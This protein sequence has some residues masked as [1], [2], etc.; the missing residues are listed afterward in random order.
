MGLS[1]LESFRKLIR[2][3]TVRVGEP[4][5]NIHGAV[6]V[7]LADV[8]EV[9]TQTWLVLRIN[10]SQLPSLIDY[11][12]AFAEQSSTLTLETAVEG[13][14]SVTSRPN[15]VL[16]LRSVVAVE[17]SSSFNLD[18]TVPGTGA[19]AAVYLD[20]T[21]LRTVSGTV[22]V[23]VTVT[24]GRHTLYVLVAAPSVAVTVPTRVSLIG[25]TDIP[26]APQWVSTETGYLDEGAGTARNI[27]RWLSDPEVGSYRVYRREPVLLAN[28]LKAGDGVVTESTALGADNTYAVVIAGDHGQA[29][30]TGSVLLVNGEAVGIVTSVVV[31]QLTA[32]NPATTEVDESTYSTAVT[33]RLPVELETLPNLVG[34]L[35]Y[36][37]SFNEIARVSRVVNTSIV[38]YVDSA[39]NKDRAY[40]YV[41]RATGLVDET[42]LSPMSTVRYMV[43][44][45][46]TPP[47]PIDFLDDYP[48]ILNRQVTVKFQTPTDLDYAGVNVY[49]RTEIQNSTPTG[50]EPYGVSSISG[51]RL[52][53]T[54]DN[55]EFPVEVDN[56][57]T[58]YLLQFDI[59]EY[60]TYVFTI[61]SNTASAVTLTEAIPQ[62]I[63]TA[64]S[65][66]PTT[67]GMLIFK[68]TQIRT[69]AGLPNR[70]DELQ[71][72]ADNYG[73][74]FFCSFD[75]AGN[76]QRLADAVT[77]EYTP[78]NDVFSQ[79]PV[80]GIRQLVESEQNVFVET[81][82]ATTTLNSTT[83]TVSSTSALVAGMAVRGNANIP[84]GTTVISVL[85]GTTVQL[86]NPATAAGT[87][88]TTFALDN[89]VQYALLELWAYNPGVADAAKFDGVTLYYQREVQDAQ[90]IALNPIPNSDRPFPDLIQLE[91]VTASVTTTAGSVTATMTDTSGLRLGM[92]I[93][94]N[95]RIPANTT[96]ATVVNATTFTLS[97]NATSTG[98]GST[99]FTLTA[100]AK[101]VVDN[102]TATRSRFV[103]LNREY[104]IIRVWAETGSGLSSDITT[105]IADLDTTPEVQVESYIN[106]LNNT[107]RFSVVADDDTNGFSWQ[108]DTG[109]V[110][111]V[112]TRTIKRV[113]VDGIP[114]AL[115]ERK[116][117]RVVPY[118]RYV[119]GPPVQLLDPGSEVVL[120]LVRTPRSSVVFDSKDSAGNRSSIAVTATFSM[121]PAP[122]KL[123]SNRAGTITASGGQYVL[124]DSQTPGWTT[125]AFRTTATGFFYL[126][127][128]P[129][130]GQ[131]RPTIVR[132]IT[133][134]TSNTLTIANNLQDYVGIGA[135]AYDILDGAVLVRRVP[136]TGGPGAFLPTAGKEYYSRSDEAFEIE[137]YA[138]KNG[139]YPENVRRAFIDDDTLPRLRDFAYSQTTIGGETFTDLGFGSADDDA[140]FW[141]VYEKKGG[142]PTTDGQA[143]TTT[144]PASMSKI[145][146]A[147][148]RF[149]GSI[150]QTSYR[151]SAASMTANDLW[152]A[153]AV[154]KNSFGEVGY[155]ATAQLTVGATELPRIGEVTLVPNVGTNTVTVTWTVSSTTNPATGVIVEAYRSD[156]Q[157]APVQGN[158][159]AGGSFTLNVGETIVAT[160][161]VSRNWV[162]SATLSGYNTITR[163]TTFQVQSG[164]GG[165]GGGL[166]FTG[167][168][169]IYDLGS[170]D[171]QSCVSP[172]SR[173]HQRRIIWDLTIPGS[174]LTYTSPYLVNIEYA[175][176]TATTANPS[177]TPLVVGL[178]AAERAYLDSS[179]CLYSDLAAGTARYWYYRLVLTDLNGTPL[180]PTVIIPGIGDVMSECSG[181]NQF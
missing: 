98:S 166:T 24:A 167:S 84:A 96:V 159:T 146:R 92:V 152:Y 73:R 91:T 40:E 177:Y 14:L 151:R 109:T 2:Q 99:T 49:H 77:W 176:T 137:F 105:Y 4:V 103:L 164:G 64:I 76:E 141:E 9:R 88:S 29:L 124:T 74:Y 55:N 95:A 111:A 155:P 82:N 173:P 156:N 10:G 58:G 35:P 53:V 78:D 34:Q 65:A 63:V 165:T 174:T 115:G 31:T 93:T 3:D 18:I 70:L 87:T 110:T 120:E 118:G 23:P 45:D 126:Q 26:R 112:D 38:E 130:E 133:A 47:G 37:G 79:P 147:Y 8:G 61:A 145:D 86:S 101:A 107:V 102:P 153:I 89:H 1:L 132:A 144:T 104:A 7:D 139:S 12:D 83:A 62:D 22:A 13:V 150:D 25:E 42:V 44:G 161:G 15:T 179:F 27:L 140:T 116:V 85:S 80:V 178:P 172:L 39:V 180:G 52:V 6:R 160:G 66:S 69:D 149:A 158:S 175:M 71:F 36:V 138:T 123:V 81:L 17:R 90:P 33:C 72:L 163:N 50:F 136:A 41:L 169:S 11:F 20:G 135:I 30:T 59:E 100:K 128:R 114:L 125:N 94:G 97:A 171:S 16:L 106:P 148:L 134:N 154:P 68:D 56:D 122:Q 129:T 117:L 168:A 57:L 46:T 51:N 113:E 60:D 28:L 131:A 32:D 143:P 67:V 127:L 54:S 48:A 75:R 121:V 162:V 43:A 157:N 108:V 142:W 19:S 170:C 21:L 5:G 181:G 119:A